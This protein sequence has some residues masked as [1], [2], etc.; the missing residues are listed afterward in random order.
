MSR[1]YPDSSQD[2]GCLSFLW[3]VFIVPGLAVLAVGILIA[4]LSQPM[5]GGQP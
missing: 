4:L 5:T 2:G 1:D 3:W